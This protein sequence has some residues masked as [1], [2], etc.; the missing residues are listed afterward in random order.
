MGNMDLVFIL[1]LVLVMYWFF[2][3][4]QSKKA[5]EQE[6]FLEDL[7]KGQ[8]VVT[9]GGIHGKITKVEDDLITILVDSKTYLNIE[10]STISLELTYSRFGKSEA[11]SAIKPA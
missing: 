2:V 10:K 5:K 7:A 3:R 1:L 11:K 9:I 6:I 4:P 8:N